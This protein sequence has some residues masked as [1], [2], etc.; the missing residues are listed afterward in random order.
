MFS[1]HVRMCVFAE[2]ERNDYTTAFICISN[3]FVVIIYQVDDVF[4]SFTLPLSYNVTFIWICPKQ[5]K[6][7]KW[8]T[9]KKQRKR[10]REK[11][12]PKAKP[13][14]WDY[15]HKRIGF[16]YE[17][18]RVSCQPKFFVLLWT[19]RVQRNDRERKKSRRWKILGWHARFIPWLFQSYAMCGSHCCVNSVV[20]M[21]LRPT[22]QSP[23]HTETA[24]RKWQEKY[25]TKRSADAQESS[26]FS[27]YS[28][29]QQFIVKMWN[30]KCERT[31]QYLF[32]SFALFFS[33]F[34]IKNRFVVDVSIALQVNKRLMISLFVVRCIHRI[35]WAARNNTHA[36]PIEFRRFE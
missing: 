23:L 16:A 34:A 17:C 28:I 11:T 3:W 7:R 2:R 31:R 30:V 1:L 12:Q 6:R 26:S 5:T 32:L 10:K 24:R 18:E 22:H 4:R 19:T 20:F 29:K 15:I 8:R 9:R 36:K 13:N 14:K 27:C 35:F 25:D 33:L 21:R